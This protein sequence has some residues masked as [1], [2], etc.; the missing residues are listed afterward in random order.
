VKNVE[1]K[2]FYLRD[3]V[4][5]DSAYDEK[6]SAKPTEVA[7]G[8]KEYFDLIKLPGI[9]KYLSVGKQL[10]LVF[11]GKSYRITYRESA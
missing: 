2:T 5:T 6:T 3:G 8:S 4:W 7:F 10:V 11:N 1:D 9:A